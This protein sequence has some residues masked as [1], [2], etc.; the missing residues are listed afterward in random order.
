M[1]GVDWVH[2]NLTT[3]RVIC[4]RAAARKT[5][6]SHG[7]AIVDNAT[8]NVSIPSRE[9]NVRNGSRDVHARID[10]ATRAADDGQPDTKG[11]RRIT[12]NP[13]RSAL[14][15]YS[16]DGQEWKGSARVIVTGGYAYEV[17]K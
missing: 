4:R 6:E 14:F 11:L 7:F 10:G 13:F 2:H 12:Y 1:S 3:K 9:R 15:H 8:P 16:D 17:K 5:R